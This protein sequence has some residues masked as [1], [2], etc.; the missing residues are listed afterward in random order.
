MRQLVEENRKRGK[1]DLE[2]ELIDTGIFHENRYFDIFVE[3][4]KGGPDDIL[5]RLEAFNR[6][7]EPAELA[8]AAHPLVS[9][10]LVL[11][12]GRAQTAAAAGRIRGGRSDQARP[13]LL[14]QPLALLR[15]QPE[16]LFTENETNNRA[17]FQRRK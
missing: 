13:L 2:F 6:G 12:I 14:R 7:P 16:F 11:G 8:S 4:A 1:R 9:Q 17:T 5:I 3:Y 15:R 10:H